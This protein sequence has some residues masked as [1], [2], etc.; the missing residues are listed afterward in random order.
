MISLIVCRSLV[1]LFI[2]AGSIAAILVI[3]SVVYQCIKRANYNDVI[4]G[5]REPGDSDYEEEEAPIF[6]GKTNVSTNTT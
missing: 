1:I 2:A 3:I 4:G 6:S 5:L